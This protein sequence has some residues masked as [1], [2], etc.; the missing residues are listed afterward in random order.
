MSNIYPFFSAVKVALESGDNTQRSTR[1]RWPGK[2]ARMVNN[3][4]NKQVFVP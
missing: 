2:S 4:R 3:H 1:I